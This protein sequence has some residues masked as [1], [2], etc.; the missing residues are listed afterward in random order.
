MVTNIELD[1]LLKD[2]PTLFHMAEEGAWESIAENGLLSTTALLDRFGIEG[3]E[4]QAIEACHRPEPVDIMEGGRLAARV[5]DQIPMSDNG[6]IRALPDHLSPRDWYKILN[7][8][9]F[10]W[11]NQGRLN[12]LLNAKT[13][14]TQFH[15]VLEVDAKSFVG[16]YRDKVWLCPINSGCTKPYPHPRDESAFQRI[17]AYPYATWRKKRSVGERVVELAVD[18]S[19]PDIR[20]FT[21]RVTRRKGTEELGV[22]WQ[23]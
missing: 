21:N 8:K 15:D 23:P 5:R 22:L 13:Y 7:A 12:R 19:I 14:R 2:C 3:D 10:F 9:V 6:L 11:L 16:S 18:Y 1:E 17:D 20:A 4:R